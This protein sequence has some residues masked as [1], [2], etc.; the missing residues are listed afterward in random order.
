MEIKTILSF[1]AANWHYLLLLLLVLITIIRTR[2]R[3]YFWKVRKT[4]E[5]LKFKQFFREWGKGIDGV[6]PL[7]QARSKVWG[8]WITLIGLTSGI[9][10]N[11]IVRVE[12][13]WIWLTVVLFGSLIISIIS[14]IGNIQVLRRLKL[15]DNQVKELTKK[16]FDDV[17]IIK[18]PQ[19]KVSVVRS[20]R[21]GEIVR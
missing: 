7:Q 18:E 1:L 8:F 13:Q 5:H 10:I 19:K 6:T 11:V 15:I 9:I 12:N 20:V 17:K 3:G 14:Q 4:G 16:N 21:V 2:V